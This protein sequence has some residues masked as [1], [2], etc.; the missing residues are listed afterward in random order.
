MYFGTTITASR[1]SVEALLAELVSAKF[2]NHVV[3]N[4]DP[5]LLPIA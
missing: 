3:H 1:V 5:A 2:V 4:G